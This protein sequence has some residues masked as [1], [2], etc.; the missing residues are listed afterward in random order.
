M[1]ALPPEADDYRAVNDAAQVYEQTMLDALMDAK[2]AGTPGDVLTTLAR[3]LA[4]DDEWERY[5]QEI[6]P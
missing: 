6:R 2:R 5:Q 4:L 1:N 3:G